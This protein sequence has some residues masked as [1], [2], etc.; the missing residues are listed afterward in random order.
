[1]SRTSLIE[2]ENKWNRIEDK[3][4]SVIEKFIDSGSLDI[5]D[6]VKLSASIVKE[7]VKNK[8]VLLHEKIYELAARRVLGVSESK[9]L[10]TG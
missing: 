3:T 2:T 7:C 8:Q 5:G 6:R 9:K 10:K 4:L 1:M